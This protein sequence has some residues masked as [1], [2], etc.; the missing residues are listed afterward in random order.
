MLVATGQRDTT[1][2]LWV[3]GPAADIAL[4]W[5]WLPVAL[6]MH[7]V[8]ANITALQSIMGVIFLISFAHQPLTLGLV[9]GDPAQRTAHPR[10]Y[11]WAPWVAFALIVIGL[12]VSLTAIALMAGLWNAEHTLMQRYGVMRIYGRKV[13][14]THGRIEKPMLIVWL[15]TAVAYLGGYV[16]LQR[17]VHKLGFGGTNARSVGL[18]A[19][20]SSVARV[21]FWAGAVVGL[22]LVARWW[23]AERRLGAVASRPKHWYALGTAGLV[24]AVMIDPIA[25]IGGYVAA[26]AIEYFAVVHSSLRKRSDA[27]PVAAATR[28]PFRRAAVYAAYFVAIGTLIYFSRSRLDGRLYAFAVL[29][30]GALHILY[31]GFVWKLRRPAV[32]A[33]LGITPS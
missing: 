32:A 2:R 29:F 10:L 14:D 18:L 19:G 25:G 21:L 16:D 23:Q 3:H 31:D 7:S 17:M 15:I 26:H 11:R 30:F 4:G 12:N 1:R 20:L 33:S 28:T 27:A 13:G 9:Y 22:V 24:I 6:L 8:E 5:C